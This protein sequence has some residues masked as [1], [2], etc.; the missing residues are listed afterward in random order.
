MGSVRSEE[1]GWWG[2]GE[3]GRWGVNIKQQPTTN[4]K[5]PTINNQQSTT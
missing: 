1:V 4:N 2:G 5:Q 3:M